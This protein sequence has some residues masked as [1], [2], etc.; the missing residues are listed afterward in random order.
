LSNQ[1]IDTGHKVGAF[2]DLALENYVD[3][4]VIMWGAVLC[5]PCS[6]RAKDMTVRL[7]LIFEILL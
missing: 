7:T 2:F 6:K 5:K 1:L 3:I 4:I